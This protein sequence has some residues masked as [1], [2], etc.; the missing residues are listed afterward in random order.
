MSAACLYRI[1]DTAGGE[2]DCGRPAV[3]VWEDGEVVLPMCRKHDARAL[4]LPDHKRAG[5]ER[6]AI[7]QPEAVLA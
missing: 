6:K 2:H 3:A 1:P 5:W 7:E 4:S